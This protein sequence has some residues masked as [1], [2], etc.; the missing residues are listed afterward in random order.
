MRGPTFQEAMDDLRRKVNDLG[1]LILEEAG[2]PK[3]VA[4]LD[5][6]I[7]RWRLKRNVRRHHRRFKNLRVSEVD[8]FL[9]EIG[10]TEEQFKSIRKDT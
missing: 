7:F 9:Q 4:W 8:D 2:I 10:V 3:L 1:W 5:M 6:I